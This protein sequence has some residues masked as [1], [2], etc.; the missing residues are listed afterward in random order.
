M[1][2]RYTVDSDCI[3][4]DEYEFYDKLQGKELSDEEVVAKLNFYEKELSF[5]ISYSSLL[6]EKL[7]EHNIPITIGFERECD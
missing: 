7:D 4:C 1:D 6:E 2:E 5:Y 3:Y